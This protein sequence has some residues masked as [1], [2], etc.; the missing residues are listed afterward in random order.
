MASAYDNEAIDTVTTP[1]K[2]NPRATPATGARSPKGRATRTSRSDWTKEYEYVLQSP[3]QQQDDLRDRGDPHALDD[4]VLLLDEDAEAGERGAEQAELDHQ[5]G[6]EGLPGAAGGAELHLGEQRAGLGDVADASGYALGVAREVAPGDGR[7][8]AGGGE[9][10]GEHAQGGGLACA[11][12]PQEAEDLAALDREVD[13][14]YG[15]DGAHTLRKET[16]AAPET[17]CPS[18]SPAS[19]HGCSRR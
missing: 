14:A 18:W 4:A 16:G 9:Q 6:D 1:T 3:P 10:G 19:S 2:T 8:A 7:G 5:P 17:R 15:L 13:A 11:V 12:G